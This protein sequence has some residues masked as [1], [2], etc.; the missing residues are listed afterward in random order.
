MH[1]TVK[2][3]VRGGTV[4][5]AA[6]AMI[7]LAG[8]A[9]AYVRRDPVDIREVYREPGLGLRVWGHHGR[10][11]FAGRPGGRYRLRVT[12]HTGGRVLVV[13]SVDGVNIL[14]GETANYDQRGY[15]F[16]PYETYDLSGWRKSDTEIAAFAFA[17]LP[18][19]YAARTGR[20]GD[21]GVIGMAV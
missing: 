3:N 9:Q 5:A 18:Q 15:V 20:P 17:P 10:Q 2:A 7:G 13:M 8:S 14:T 16:S 4:L 21:V 1:M 12:N 11:Y 6:I 19:S